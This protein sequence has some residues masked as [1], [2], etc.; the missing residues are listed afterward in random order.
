MSK[1]ILSVGGA[2]LVLLTLLALIGCRGAGDSI[3]PK[4]TLSVTKVILAENALVVTFN[5]PL[6]EIDKT[7]GNGYTLIK[8]NYSVSKATTALVIGG[9]EKGKTADSVKLLVTNVHDGLA[10]QDTFTVTLRGIAAWTYIVK[11][12]VPVSAK[13]ISSTRI[14]VTFSDSIAAGDITATQFTIAGTNVTGADVNKA[15]ADADIV[16]LEAGGMTGLTDA[17]TDLRVT[18]TPDET[19]TKLAG[20]NKLEVAAFT[21]FKV[22]TNTLVPPLTAAVK[23]DAS[24]S[25]TALT[26]EFSGE[27]YDAKGKLAAKADVLNLFDKTGTVT[28]SSATVGDDSKTVVFVLAAAADTDTIIPN[29]NGTVLSAKGA[30]W[31]GLVTFKTDKWE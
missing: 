15:T 9:V 6:A 24:N 1:K 7:L 28:I 21:E 18:Y 23:A 3:P 4:P 29:A 16:T 17:V 30:P 20:F 27:L 11:A 14:A 10:A 8:E 25:D 22:D 5:A 12:P 26:L 13:A 31:R 19:G 2:A